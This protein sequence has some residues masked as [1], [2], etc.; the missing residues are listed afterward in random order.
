MDKMIRHRLWSTVLFL[1]FGA[2]IFVCI[3]LQILIF[4]QYAN[5]VTGLHHLNLIPFAALLGALNESLPRSSMPMLMWFQLAA[6]VVP[7]GF[8]LFLWVDDCTNFRSIAAITTGFSG[9]LCGT[10]YML[11][12]P[13]FDIDF[14]VSSLCGAYCGYG[15]AIACVEFFFTKR[16]QPLLSQRPKAHRKAA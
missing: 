14:M 10:H 16:L 13:I 7:L 15:I 2:Y 6:L 5:Q 8:C 12:A 4:K 1:G 3:G 11:T 9:L